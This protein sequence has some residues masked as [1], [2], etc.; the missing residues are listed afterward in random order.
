V[1]RSTT[2]AGAVQIGKNNTQPGGC[3]LK[4]S[5]VDELQQ[6]KQ[7]QQQQQILLASV[8]RRVIEEHTAKSARQSYA[9]LIG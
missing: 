5:V 1:G 2:Q 3:S 7:E 9:N 6:Q 4:H 8:E